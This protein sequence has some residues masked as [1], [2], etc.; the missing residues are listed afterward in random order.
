MTS[1]LNIAILGASG[2]TGAELI[3]LLQHHPYANIA[4]LS[5]DSK[6]GQAMGA[7][8]PHLQFAGLPDLQRIDDID[9]AAM[10]VVF[11]CLPHA[12]T[13]EVVATLPES[14]IVIDLSA[15]FRLRDPAVY[16][17]WYGRP[18]QALAHQ[19]KA[20]YGLSEWARDDITT[21][22]LI[23]NP[24]C[25]PTSAQLPLLPLL[26]AGLISMQNIIIDSKSGVTGAGRKAAENLLFTELND[27]FS[28]YAVG[29]HRHR[30][31]IEQ[32]LSDAASQPVTV[33][34]TP[35]LLP[36]NRGILSTIYVDLREG[37]TLSQL[38]DCLQQR[39][40][41]EP[42]VHLLPEGQHPST[43]MVRGSNHCMMNLFADA[44]PNKAILVSVIDN[45]VKGASG[46]AVQNMNIRLGWDETLGLQQL[47]VFP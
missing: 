29:K 1:S 12:M 38:R 17:A 44:E 18:H 35:H 31:E 22:Q 30:P 47:A 5:G 14:L 34:F 25:Y 19:A 42:F 21:A 39:Y 16:E 23:A 3:R 6:A 32:G 24:G 9:L 2:Y 4:A 10:D 8:Y 20:V 37:A 33:R 11:C 36:M 40:A 28:A 15:D 43:A 27:G 26:K 45:L 13:Q 46:Q 7:V 41:N